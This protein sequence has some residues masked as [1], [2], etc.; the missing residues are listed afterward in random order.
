MPPR[1]SSLAE[2]LPTAPMAPV[3]REHY[4]PEVPNKRPQELPALEGARGF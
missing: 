3:P 2:P 4:L 1:V